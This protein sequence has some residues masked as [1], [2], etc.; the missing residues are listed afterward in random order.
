MGFRGF[1][2]RGVR[3]SGVGVRG[4]GSRSG[5]LGQGIGVGGSQLS[6]TPKPQLQ[7]QPNPPDLNPLTPTQPAPQTYH[8]CVANLSH[9]HCCKRLSEAYAQ[10]LGH[11]RTSNPLCGKSSVANL[12]CGASSGNHPPIVLPQKQLSVYTFIITVPVLPWYYLSIIN[13]NNP[14]CNQVS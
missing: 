5:E 13:I 10:I 1:Q 3:V 12:P 6:P 9:R 4:L 11:I 8:R 14:Y 7:P 2:V